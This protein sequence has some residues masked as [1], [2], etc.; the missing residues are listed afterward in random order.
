MKTTNANNI[1]N[2]I[3]KKTKKQL[4]QEKTL[5]LKELGVKYS[6]ELTENI[7]KWEQILYDILTKHNYNFIFQHP[8]V[9][10][11]NSLFI[12]DF[13][14]PEYKLFLEADG[15]STHGSKAQIKKDNKRTSLLKKEGYTPIRL[16]NSQIERYS[17]KEIL[18]IINQ[19]IKNVK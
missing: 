4:F 19:R 3:V 10:K 6:K 1:K 9:T 12:L 5:F 14:F 7:T 2:K 18:T 16:F 13:Y 11:N 17:E 8:V 15:K